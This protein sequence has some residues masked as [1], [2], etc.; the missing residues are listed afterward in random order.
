[1]IQ[2]IF[3]PVGQGAF[4]SERHENHNIVYDCGTHYFN[5]GKKGI[6]NTIFQSFSKDEIIDMKKYY[7]LT[8][9]R[10]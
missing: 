4:Y 8:Y 7:Y 5:R 3:H 10:L 1:M 2:R 6:K 9:L